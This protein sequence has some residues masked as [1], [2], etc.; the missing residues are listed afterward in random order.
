MSDNTE[1]RCIC[2][3]SHCRRCG[4]STGA[5]IAG[6]L[7]VPPFA[8]LHDFPPATSVRANQPAGGEA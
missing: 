2:G 1:K 8:G 6:V 5:A 4:I 3:S 7:C